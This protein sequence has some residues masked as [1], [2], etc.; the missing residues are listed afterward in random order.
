MTPPGRVRLSLHS[1][2]GIDW[3]ALGRAIAEDIEASVEVEVL[4]DVAV[5][6]V[7]AG[8]LV[9]VAVG[10]AAADVALANNGSFLQPGD[11]MTSV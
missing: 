9:R 7:D 2:D 3:D 10:R 5:V 8:W 11:R 6:S 1:T 4:G